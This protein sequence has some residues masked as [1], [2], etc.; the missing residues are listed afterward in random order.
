MKKIELTILNLVLIAANVSL[1]GGSVNDGL[2]YLPQAVA[3]GQ[4]YRLLTH[5]FVHVSVY[6]L[7]IDGLAFF[8]LYWQMEE[9][10]LIKRM[11]CL[12]GIHV[13]VLAAVT[14]F[15]PLTATLGYCGLSGIDHGLMALWCLEQLVQK[16][17][18]RTKTAL[19]TLGIL[20]GKSVYEMLTGTMLFASFHPGSIGTPIVVS[21][22]GG[23]LGAFVVF[24]LLNHTQIQLLFQENSQKTVPVGR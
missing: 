15:S 22:A 11:A 19:I 7:L 21:H 4:F 5:P 9:K 3:S 1:L 14:F 12:L 6:H 23:I 13:S 17:P 2:V 10:S 18:L 8:L 16:D 24:V 20:I